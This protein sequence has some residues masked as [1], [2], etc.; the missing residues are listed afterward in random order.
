ML[1]LAIFDIDNT[2]INGQ[3]QQ[4]FLAYLQ[5]RGDVNFIVYLKIC[6][7][8]ITYKIGLINNPRAVMEYAFNFLKGW[9]TSEMDGL[10]NTFF[11]E[12]L[13]PLFY[14]GGINEI[15]KHQVKNREI[16]LVSNAIEPLVKK[17]A[18]F[19]QIK[20]YIC[21]ELEITHD[22]YTGKIRG[23][24]VYGKNKVPLI[25]KFMSANNVDL[26]NTWGYGDHLSDVYFLEMVAHP[27]VVNPAKKLL[28]IAKL[29]NW[30]ILDFE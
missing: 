6:L 4:L 3:T 13:R 9:P 16:L 25:Q 30:P 1:E 26:N 15:K 5:K 22:R 24:I 23:D 14:T 21:T 28:E 12:D 7:W 18:E 19:L 11:D 20:N 29:R 8:F 10:I 2:L 17:I 27:I